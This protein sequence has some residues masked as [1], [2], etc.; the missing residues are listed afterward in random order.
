MVIE[1]RTGR[2]VHYNFTWGSDSKDVELR[3]G[4]HMDHSYKYNPNGLPR[5]EL[6]VRLA[7]GLMDYKGLLFGRRYIIQADT[8]DL[9]NVTDDLGRDIMKDALS[10]QGLGNPVVAG[11]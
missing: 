6:E 4:Y 11:Q 7:Q 8:R 3:P 5:P 9:E 10:A 2:T 1:N